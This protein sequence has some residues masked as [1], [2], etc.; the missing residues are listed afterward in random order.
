[1]KA[2]RRGRT[3]EGLH[4][5]CK[6]FRFHRSAKRNNGNVT[7]RGSDPILFVGK[8]TVAVRKT[9]EGE[10]QR[11]TLLSKLLGEQLLAFSE[12]AMVAARSPTTYKAALNKELSI[13][14]SCC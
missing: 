7:R 6:E 5:C 9:M 3:T 10:V 4:G 2:G 14:S 11:N 1:M 8:A 12:Q 13:Q